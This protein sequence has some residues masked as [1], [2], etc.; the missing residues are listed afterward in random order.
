MDQEYWDRNDLYELAWSKPFTELAKE[1]E[2]SDV[3]L[4]G[5]TGF[6][7]ATTVAQ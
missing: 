2:I 6:E 1:Y 3:G 5:D 7:P 4:L